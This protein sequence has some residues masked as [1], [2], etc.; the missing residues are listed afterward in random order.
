[1]DEREHTIHDATPLP[2]HKVRHA[3]MNTQTGDSR[4][5]CILERSM[6]S[7]GVTDISRI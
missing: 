7:A 4:S 1:M 5:A 2:R 3:E 6:R